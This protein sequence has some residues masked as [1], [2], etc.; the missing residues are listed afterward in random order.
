MQLNRI[1]YI[2]IQNIAIMQRLLL[3]LI[4]ITAIHQQ[5]F[6]QNAKSTGTV[7]TDTKNTAGG[8]LKLYPNPATTYTNIYVDWNSLQSFK[9]VI[10]DMQYKATLSSIEVK[11]RKNYQYA[12]D[13]SKLPAGNY[14]ITIVN[15]N[16]PDME[17]VLAVSR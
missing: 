16:T 11:S 15:P 10:Y 13:V 2:Y 12:L 17:Q 7:N 8:A 4:F 14:K 5:S 1:L 3:S 6:A 9:I